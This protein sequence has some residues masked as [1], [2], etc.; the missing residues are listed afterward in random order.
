MPMTLSAATD[1]TLRQNSEAGVAAAPT[2]AQPVVGSVHA[3][4]RLWIR[5]LEV[6]DQ[7]TQTELD[8]R[9]HSVLRGDL[10]LDDAGDPVGQ[11]RQRGGLPLCQLQRDF[12][13]DDM[14][15]ET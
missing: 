2:A 4:A 9:D 12:G 3:L 7:G 6:V 10:G 5:Y 8:H 11:R 1:R 13:H 14:L 15:P